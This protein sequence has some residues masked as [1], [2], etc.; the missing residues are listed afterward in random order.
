MKSDYQETGRLYS[1]LDSYMVS[2]RKESEGAEIYWGSSCQFKTQKKYK[3]WLLLQ[4]N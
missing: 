4:P 3:A 2:Q 1:K